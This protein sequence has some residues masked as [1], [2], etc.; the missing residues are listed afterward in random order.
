MLGIRDLTQA[1][2][3]SPFQ[4]PGGGYPVPDGGRTDGRMEI[5]LSN[6]Y[7]C[8]IWRTHSLKPFQ[9]IP[10]ETK[11]SLTHMDSTT[12]IKKHLLS[13]A[14]FDKKSF[15]FKLVILHPLSKKNDE[16][17]A[18]EQTHTITYI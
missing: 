5:L 10:R 16:I 1:L 18:K 2:Q 8:D 17:A 3:S 9:K 7:I 13:R 6:I 12:D 4:N 15:F 14:K 11:N